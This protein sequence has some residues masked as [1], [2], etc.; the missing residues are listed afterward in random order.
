VRRK[1]L[2][3][4]LSK[5]FSEFRPGDQCYKFDLKNPDADYYFKTEY[6]KSNEVEDLQEK[7][8]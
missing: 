7:R 6:S 8:D 2:K 3:G 1:E 5:C 4:V